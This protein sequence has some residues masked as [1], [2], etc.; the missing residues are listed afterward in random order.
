MRS[1]RGRQRGQVDAAVRL[2]ATRD[3]GGNARSAGSQMQITRQRRERPAGPQSQ[4]ARRR[5]TPCRR[6]RRRW[7]GEAF[8]LCR[9][10]PARRIDYGDG[11][12]TASAECGAHSIGLQPR[13]V[14]SVGAMMDPVGTR[15]RAGR[16]A[17]ASPA[18][19]PKLA[20]PALRPPKRD[21]GRP[22]KPGR[23]RR[24][25]RWSPAPRRAA[26]GVLGQQSGD[27]DHEVRISSGGFGGKNALPGLH[28]D[29]RVRETGCLQIADS[30]AR[31][32]SGK[33][34]AYT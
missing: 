2:H 33:N 3:A 20:R 21:R 7:P 19:R 29:Q 6:P 14:G 23:D 5:A 8:A 32:H 10:G 27:D 24:R 11:P 1:K 13:V 17:S 15:Q 28:P 31:A 9:L 18:A 30:A 16:R 25:P 22:S 12:G 26:P 34:F 4:P